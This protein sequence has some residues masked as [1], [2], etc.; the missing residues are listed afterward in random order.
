VDAVPAV[1]FFADGATAAAGA[2]NSA[3]LI[4]HWLG[5]ER[6]DARVRPYGGNGALGGQPWRGRRLAAVTLALVNGGIAVQAAFGQALFSA[7]RLGLPVEPLFAPAPWF[8]ARLPLF[9]GTMLLSVLI[10]RRVR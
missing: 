4:G 10:L 8:A 2:F 9:A 6:A 5:R 7:H 3:W 1:I